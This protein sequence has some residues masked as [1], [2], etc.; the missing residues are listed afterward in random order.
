MHISYTYT[1]NTFLYYLHNRNTRKTLSPVKSPSKCKTLMAINHMAKSK[2][3]KAH[4][5]KETSSHTYT[6]LQLGASK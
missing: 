2:A 1:V 6:N 4:H 5:A 3:Y